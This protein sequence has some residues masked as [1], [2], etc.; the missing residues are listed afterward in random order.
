MIPNA[1]TFP[2][3]N[4]MA[5]ESELGG[6]EGELSLHFSNLEALGEQEAF[7]DRMLLLELGE[8]RWKVREGGE[9]KE[10]E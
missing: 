9:K 2:T 4:H 3:P 8:G 10:R 6:W 1:S 7:H 5:S